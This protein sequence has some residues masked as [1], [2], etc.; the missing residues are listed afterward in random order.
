VQFELM[1]PAS[2][3]LLIDGAGPLAAAAPAENS[4]RRRA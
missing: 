4:A 1:L 3:R 2:L